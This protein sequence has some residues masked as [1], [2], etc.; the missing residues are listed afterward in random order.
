MDSHRLFYRNSREIDTLKGVHFN[1]LF[2]LMWLQCH[3]PYL[4]D[5]NMNFIGHSRGILLIA[6]FLALIIEVILLRA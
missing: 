3:T 6:V 2:S 5:P 1:H 4:I